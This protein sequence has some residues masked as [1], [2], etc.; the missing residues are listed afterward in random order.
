MA[1]VAAAA[2]AVQVTGQVR[3]RTLFFSFF[4]ISVVPHHRRSGRVRFQ[5]PGDG[6]RLGRAKGGQG[7]GDASARG[8]PA[9]GDVQNH[10]S[11][12]A[13]LLL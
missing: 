9:L 1:V 4:L 13:C 3:A 12:G 8:R 11:V 2:A 6:V 7:E 5:G 10:A